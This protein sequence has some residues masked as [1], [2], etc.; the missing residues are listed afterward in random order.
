MSEKAAAVITD[1]L[2]LLV[3][4]DAEADIEASEGKSAIRFMNRL[5]ARLAAGGVNLGYTKVT[6]LGD[7]V[8][9]ADGAMDGLIAN[10]ALG[11]APMY[12]AVVTLELRELAKEGLTAMYDL[13]IE[14]GDTSKPSTLPIGSGNTGSFSN[15]NF[16]FY[17]EDP[18]LIATEVNASIAVEDSTEV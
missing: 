5:M 9:I 2:Q 18:D 4:Q 14:I 16:K 17:S 12:K 3:V 13:A 11:L 6:N 10:L 15:R 7:T 1:A 8:T